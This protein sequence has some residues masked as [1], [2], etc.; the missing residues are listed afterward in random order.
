VRRNIVFSTNKHACGNKTTAMSIFTVSS[1]V[2]R[3]LFFVTFMP[4]SI[5]VH[6]AARGAGNKSSAVGV[7]AL[8]PAACRRGELAMSDDNILLDHARRYFSQAAQGTDM[9]KIKLL[10][11]L[12][13]E[14][15]RLAHHSADKRGSADTTGESTGAAAGPAGAAPKARG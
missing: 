12:G 7:I 9:K 8:L 13:L 14:F 15:L 3:R 11:E 5:F 10:A 4:R 1:A 2:R 6:A